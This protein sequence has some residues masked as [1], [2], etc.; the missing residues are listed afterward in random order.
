MFFQGYQNFSLV[1]MLSSL[2]GES[3]IKGSITSW[4]QVEETNLYFPIQ[5]TNTITNLS[6]RGKQSHDEISLLS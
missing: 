3:E 5:K 6:M 1:L 2:A 4:L